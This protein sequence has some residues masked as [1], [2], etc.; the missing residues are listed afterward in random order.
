[1]RKKKVIAN[2]IFSLFFQIVTI[3]C[4]F[5]VPKQIISTF[6]SDINGLIISITQFLAYITLLD[7]GFGPIIKSLLYK[8]IAKKNK[9]EVEQILK[10]SEKIFRR[11]A[12]IF[13]IYILVLCIVF[14]IILNEKFD[15]IF[16]V[17]LIIIIS[18]STFFEYF[19]GM[20]YK[21]YLQAKQSS[22][23]ISIIQTTTLLISTITIVI[24][25][26]INASIHI[27]KLFSGV[28]FLLRPLFLSTY[29]KRKYKIDL[30]NIESN[31]D[32]KQKWDALAQHIAY[33]IHTNTDVMI[34]TLFCSLSEVSVYSI[35]YLILTGIESIICN[36]FI[37][38]IDGAFGDMIAKGEKNKLKDSF[39]IYEGL[40]LTLC[41][42]IFVCT[43]ILII[44]FVKVYTIGITDANYI[45]TIFASIFVIAEF[46]YII[47]QLYYSLVKVS[48]HFKQ[49]KKG[50]I[51]E[52]FTNI[53]IS[54]T[55]VFKFGMVGVAIGTLIAMLIRTIEIIIYTSKNILNRSILYMIKRILLI[56]TEFIIIL[57]IN[58]YIN[59]KID[60]FT[61]WILKAVIITIISSLIVFVINFIFYKENVKKLKIVFFNK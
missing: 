19:F 37:N 29:V 57:F 36:I 26:N 44:P 46:I 18:L 33:I 61:S 54:L 32:I 31:Y 50:A 47:R 35:Y 8:P 51:I 49:T 14:P 13:I 25:V 45:R 6:G 4:G 12:H 59:I 27:V 53:L 55:L 16:T 41:T 10:S 5:I 56:I 7:A 1:M 20:T 15:T 11:I 30:K 58:N 23:I 22:Y 48:G 43:F 28:I 9:K 39:N 17:S 2:I 24:L 52:A 34:L 3:I 21:L 38:S 42:I 40:Y 60:S